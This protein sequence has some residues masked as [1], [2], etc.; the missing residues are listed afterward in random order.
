MRLID[1]DRLKFVLE[2]NF[3]H[4]GGASVLEQLIDDQPTIQPRSTAGQ[5]NDCARSTDLIDRQQAID[6]LD[7]IS[8]V[9]EV[10]RSLPTIQPEPQWIPVSERVP[11]TNDPVLTTYIIN[12]DRSRKYVEE[13]S[14]YENDEYWCSPWDNYRKEGTRI[15]VIAWMPEPEAYKPNNK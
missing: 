3:G 11:E 14:Y 13:S 8:G 7:C 4:T 9:E 12:G 6:A 10:L 2:K 1:A 15:E 5:L